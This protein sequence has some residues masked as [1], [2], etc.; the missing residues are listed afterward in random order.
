MLV[1][2]SERCLQLNLVASNEK[3][4]V[5]NP[6]TKHIWVD[7]KDDGVVLMKGI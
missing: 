7:K 5:K 6:F 2:C 3:M 1:G 4:A